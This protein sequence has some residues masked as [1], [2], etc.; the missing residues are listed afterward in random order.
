MRPQ[1][2]E[3]AGMAQGPSSCEGSGSPGP[4]HSAP[5]HPARARLRPACAY[6]CTAQVLLSCPLDANFWRHRT[7]ALRAPGSRACVDHTFAEAMRAGSGRPFPARLSYTR[8]PFAGSQAARCVVLG[9]VRSAH[10][11]G[12]QTLVEKFPS[13]FPPRAFS[14]QVFSSNHS[15]MRA[16]AEES[17][18]FSS[19]AAQAECLGSGGGTFGATSK[20]SASE[21]AQDRMFGAA[22]ERW[23]AHA[24]SCA[25]CARLWICSY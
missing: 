1:G 20:P 18:F 12:R 23:R 5:L 13:Q 4:V 11:R 2:A 19:W 10:I 3:R 24:R 8:S 7:S 25:F 17:F 14:A 22:P 6:V 16:D 15:A 9:M 21:A